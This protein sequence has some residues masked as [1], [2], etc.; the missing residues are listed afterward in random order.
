MFINLYAFCAATSTSVVPG[1]VN[2]RLGTGPHTLR[3]RMK[4]GAGNVGVF[5]EFNWIIGE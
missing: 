5:N 3:V 2:G 4:D 1:A